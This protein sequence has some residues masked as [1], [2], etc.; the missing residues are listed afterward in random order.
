MAQK[1]AI[2]GDHA[3]YTYKSMLKKEMAELGYENLDFGP[4]SEASVD[5]PDHVHPLAKA[6]IAGDADL[7]ILICGSGNG[8]AMT[9]NKYKEIRAALCWTSEL[10]KL[11]REHNNANVLCIPA[12]FVTEDVAKEMTKVFLET[13]FEGGRHLNR[14]NKIA[15][16]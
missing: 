3:G 9:A 11:A 2:G 13:K 16:C 14:V 6:V 15:A 7:G 4:D 8:V 5:Y 10:A 1:I 12:R